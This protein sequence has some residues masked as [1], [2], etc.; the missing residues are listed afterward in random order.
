MRQRYFKCVCSD[1][2]KCPL[3]FK[4]N[5]C[6]KSSYIVLYQEKDKVVSCISQHLEKK[7][8]TKPVRGIAKIVKDLIEEMC[9]SDPDDPP[10]KILTRLIKNRKENNLFIIPERIN[11]ITRSSKYYYIN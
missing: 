8:T 7:S 2:I 10:K 4:V 9:R 5:S 11:T 6:L 1:D 3:K